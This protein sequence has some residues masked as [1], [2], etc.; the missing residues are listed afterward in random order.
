MKYAVEL[1]FDR[2][3]ERK[4]FALAQRVADENLST[5]FLEWKSRPHLTLACLNNVNEQKC[6]GQ[7]KAFARDHKVMPAYLGSVGSFPDTKTIFA[8]PIMTKGMYR[9]QEE[10][11]ECLKEHDKTGWEWYFPDRWTPHCTLALT[12]EEEES[13]FYRANDLILHEFQKI[14]GEF[15]A[16]GLVKITCPVEEICTIELCG[17]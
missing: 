11:H 12:G 1:Y 17:G 9:F 6:I 8:S 3:T 15:V 4:L 16:I 10:L 5:K 2:E 7:L 13:V 14:S